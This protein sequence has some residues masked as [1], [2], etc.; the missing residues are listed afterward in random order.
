MSVQPSV[1]PKRCACGNPYSRSQW[2]KL[3][4]VG[5]QADEVET[6]E[7]RDC[8]CGSTLAIAV[9]DSTVARQTGGRAAAHARAR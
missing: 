7:L 8:T 2:Q 1:W 6:L 4:L 9:V 3:A 5:Y